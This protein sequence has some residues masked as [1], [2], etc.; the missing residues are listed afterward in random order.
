MNLIIEEPFWLI[1]PC[2]LIAGLITFFLY[3]RNRRFDFGSK[4]TLILAI[5]RFFV[6]FFIAFFLLS[7]LIKTISKTTEKPIIVFAQDNSHSII[8]GKDSAFYKAEYLENTARLIGDLEKDFVVKPL[9]FS[10]LVEEGIRTDYLGKGTDYSVL[11]QEIENRFSNRNI[12]AVI[13]ATDGIY[14]AGSNPVYLAENLKYPVIPVALGDTLIHKDLVLYKVN[15]NRTALLGNNFPVEIVIKANQASGE[16]PTLKISQNGETLFSRNLPLN[17]SR[18]SQVIN[19]SLNARSKGIQ[20]YDIELSEIPGEINIVNNRQS[21]YVDVTDSKQKVLILTAAPHPDVSALK[22]AIE[23]SSGFEAEDYILTEFAQPINSFNMVIL[24][25]L[26]S[27]QPES[28]KMV[29]KVIQSELPVLFILGT[30]TNLQQFN[31]LN[32]GLTISSGKTGFNDTKAQLNDR[33]T[34]FTVNPES[35]ALMPYLPPL[36]SPFGEYQLMRNA[37]IF[38]YQKIGSLVTSIPLMAFG[39]TTSGRTG[40]IAGEGIYRWRLTDY[41]IN[42]SQ[43]SFDAMISKMLVY[44]TVKHSKSNFR[45]FVAQTTPENE[46]VQFDAEVYNESFELINQEDVNINIMNDKG[47]KFPFTFSKTN[48]SYHLNAGLFPPGN[49]NFTATVK[50]GDKI[51]SNTGQFTVTEV[52]VE[53]LNTTA[54]HNLLYQMAGKTNGRVMYPASMN[55]IPELLRQRED[56]KPIRYFHTRF[57]DLINIWWIMGLLLALLG[58]EWFIRKY[59]GGY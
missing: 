59:S 30:Q 56:I 27:G 14:N 17:T 31:A 32:T 9:I 19:I 16:N 50:N 22:Q 54:D 18:F 29:E 33:F 41:R 34:F 49:Y 6:L 25:Q 55:Q 40:Y 2:I 4:T 46:P 8:L 13:L 45:V 58:V 37:E 39:Q 47:E 7:P 38:A 1:F 52:M 44:L 35:Q 28:A 26:P 10:S 3:Y 11:F 36:T 15:Y 12:G 43:S 42:N 21:I 48:S 24:N 20:K 5:L 23:N 51:L 53:M 57:T